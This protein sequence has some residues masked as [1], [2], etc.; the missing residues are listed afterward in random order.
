MER[1]VRGEPTAI[2]RASRRLEEGVEPAR[3]SL[4]RHD[5][6]H[7]GHIAQ[8]P[9]RVGGPPWHERE[10][11]GLGEDDLAVD[12]ELDLTVEQVERLV[13]H[14]PGCGPAGCWPAVNVCSISAYDPPVSSR[15]ASVVISA[16][17]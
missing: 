6:E 7:P 2:R 10:R 17:S 4:A 16:F 3:R 8:D 11:A 5:D 13:L 1:L 12:L 9:E 15:V 14:R